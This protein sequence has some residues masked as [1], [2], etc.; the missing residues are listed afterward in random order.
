MICF[1]IWIPTKSWSNKLKYPFFYARLQVI[2]LSRMSRIFFVFFWWRDHSGTQRE[3]KEDNCLLIYSLYR[4]IW[5][6]AKKSSGI[7]SVFPLHL[8]RR[9]HVGATMGGSVECKVNE[10]SLRITEN[11]Q[12][13]SSIKIQLKKQ[14]KSKCWL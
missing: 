3:K 9:R 8:H 12:E 13:S 4:Y 1:I 5:S 7:F 11:H 6:R 2:H 14:L 10:E